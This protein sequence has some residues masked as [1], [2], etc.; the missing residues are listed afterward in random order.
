[1]RLLRSYLFFFFFN[2]TATTEIY[3]LSLHDAL[4]IFDDSFQQDAHIDGRSFLGRQL[5]VD[6]RDLADAGEERLHPRDLKLDHSQETLALIGLVDFGQHLRGCA[7]RGQRVLE[8]VRDVGGERFDEADVLV[9][10]PCQ[11]FER[12]GKIADFVVLS[13]TPK[14]S[15][16]SA[17]VVEDGGGFEAQLPQWS[18]DRRGYE[19]A[20]DDGHD[21]RDDEDAQDAEAY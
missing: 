17:A 7:D 19:Q 10:A 3:T 2:D 11:T 14:A 6:E 9:E 13:R 5:G 15:S 16:Q 1:M 18:H 8:F 12:A 21:H 4:P 20:D